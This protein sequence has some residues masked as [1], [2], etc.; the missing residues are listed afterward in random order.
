MPYIFPHEDMPT[1]I[2]AKAATT[3]RNLYDPHK[4]A[5]SPAPIAIANIQGILFLLR[6]IAHTPFPTIMNCPER[7]KPLRSFIIHSRR[8][9]GSCQFIIE[10]MTSSFP[11]STET[12]A[13][14]SHISLLTPNG[15]DW[16]SSTRSNGY[17]T[18]LSDTP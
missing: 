6:R 18:P 3:S 9:F 8:I 1:K 17:F 7:L 11:R 13:N 10:R 15:N 16:E 14:S 5:S 12:V 4:S 2:N